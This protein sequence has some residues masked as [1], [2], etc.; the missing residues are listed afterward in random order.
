M[1]CPPSVKFSIFIPFINCFLLSQTS[2]LLPRSAMSFFSVSFPYNYPRFVVT[3]FHLEMSG[4]SPVFE[5]CWSLSPLFCRPF[6]LPP[7]FVLWIST[8]FFAPVPYPNSSLMIRW[9]PHLFLFWC[10]LISGLSDHAAPQPPT[11]SC[12]T[13]WP[14]PLSHKGLPIERF[15]DF[16]FGP[17]LRKS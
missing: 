1:W 11:Y 3:S 15:S 4:C 6:S 12:P 10:K 2:S 5:P 9:F 8:L 16:D 14:L 7:F 17:E 13:S